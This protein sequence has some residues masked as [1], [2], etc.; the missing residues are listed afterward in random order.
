[1]DIF[2]WKNIC[3]LS[4]YFIEELE[5]GL[6]AYAKGIVLNGIELASGVHFVIQPG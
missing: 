2:E 1:M 4:K 6:F 5:C 3:Y